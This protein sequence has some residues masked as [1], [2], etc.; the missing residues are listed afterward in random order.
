MDNKKPIGVFDS[1][2][3]G[4]SVLADLVY[5]MPNENFIYFGDSKNAP[6]GI[7]ELK[8]IKELSIDACNF[9]VNEGV[10]AI[11]VACN[12]ATSAAIK[13]I[14]D[15]Y[16]IHI[17]GMEPALKP[18]VEQNI[19]NKSIIVMATE[20]T[21]R[22]KKFEN[23]M[24]DYAK[25]VNIIKMPASKLV[26]LVEL[27]LNN[28]EAIREYLNDILKNIDL[29]DV[30]S[31]VLGCTHFVFI[32][33]ILKDIVGPDVDII[34]GNLGTTNHLEYILKESGDLNTN[35]EEG[36]LIIYNS[37]NDDSVIDYSRELLLNRIEKLNQ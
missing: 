19:N 7:K 2:M 29:N 13:D 31:I 10:K 5:N 37:A 8:R 27:E 20:T 32:N 15:M 25:D 21:L 1:G 16:D 12:T 30:S 14:R 28:T 33:D 18:A 11:V 4:I 17:V 26:E 36:S 6:Y 9:L 24:D 35:G 34:D 3:G 23:L 22:E